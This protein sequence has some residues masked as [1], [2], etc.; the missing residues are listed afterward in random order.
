MQHQSYSKK[1]GQIFLILI[2]S[3]GLSLGAATVP[4][5]PFPQAENLA[6]HGLKPGRHPQAELNAIVLKAY[7]QWKQRYLVKSTAV[8][9]DYKI[10]FNA[11]NWTVSEAMGYGMLVTVQMAG[12]D[13]QAR[14]IFDGLNRFR[15]R[16]PSSVNPAF[17]SWQIKDEARVEKNDSAT[18]GDMDMAMALLM[19]ETQ[20]GGEQYAKEALPLIRQLGKTLVRPDFSLRL[21]DW[22]DEESKSQTGTRPSDFTT[23]HFR[24]FFR[25]TGDPLW[26]GLEDKC[27]AILEQ[28]QQDYAPGTGLIPDFAVRGQNGNWKPAPPGFLEGKNDGAFGYNSCRVPWRIGFSA[29][30]DKDPRAR[31][32]LDRLMAW[33]VRSPAKPR[34]FMAGYRL[35]GKALANYSEPSFSSPTGV[36]AMAT[37]KGEWLDQAFELA[38]EKPVDY[39]SD[40][41]ALLCLLVMSGNAWLP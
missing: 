36:A 41:I 6:Y 34:D 13:P 2:F 24:A 21:G 31:K 29:V 1:A 33:A 9:G 35:D 17:M 25:A 10:A 14:D 4:T 27:Y 19:A 15:K 8:P 22:D 16:Y 3:F 20:W 23:A 39:Y 40:S 5:R 38:A 32:I 28:L 18:D 37:E 11:R 12:A 7:L 30:Y 26:R